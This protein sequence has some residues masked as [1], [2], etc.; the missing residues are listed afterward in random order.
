MPQDNEDIINE[1]LTDWSQQ[2]IDLLKS[3]IEKAGLELTKDLYNSLRVEVIKA[4]AGD[5]ARARFYFQEHGRFKDMKTTY[6]RY[7]GNT[8]IPPVAEMEEFV[9]KT[10]LENFKY[11]PGYKPGKVP[12]ESIAIRRLAWGISRGMG[13]RKTTK[14]QKWYAKTFYKQI[15]PLIQQ[16]GNV[17]RERVAAQIKEKFEKG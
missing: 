4:T 15:T 13:K 8:G 7:N 1:V 11:I 10:G 6:S 12:A 9:K 3:S 17:T 14:P 16:V 2:T 5:L